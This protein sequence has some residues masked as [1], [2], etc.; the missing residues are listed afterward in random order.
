MSSSKNK[1]HLLPEHLI[2]QI[3][4][5][6]VIERPGS[7]LKEIIEN[8]IDSGA[9][10]IEITVLNNGLDLIQIRDNGCG[11]E[12]EDLPLAFARHAT[13]KISSFD[14]IYALNSFGFRGEA[15]ASISSISKIHCISSTTKDDLASEIKIEGGQVV[16][17]GRKQSL[18]RGTELTIQNLF[19][20]TPVRLKFIQSQASEKKYLKKIIFSFITSF[21][22][23][24]F[25]LKFDE[26]EKEIFSS[27][28]NVIDRVKSISPKI[29]DSYLYSNQMYDGLNFEILLIPKTF[30]PP[31]PFDYFFINS[32]MIL[33]KQFHKVI[34]QG[35]LNHLGSD[36]FFYIGILNGDKRNIDINVHPNKTS[37]KC[38][39]V[40]KIL[41]LISSSIREL[42]AK[43]ITIPEMKY[44][45]DMTNQS[46]DLLMNSFNSNDVKT[47][48]FEQH[49]NM[50]GVFSPHKS[51]LTEKS[52]NILWPDNEFFIHYELFGPYIFNAKILL[53]GF[54]EK[55]LKTSSPTTPLLVSL[56]FTKSKNLEEDVIILNKSGCEIENLNPST[57][58]LRG[59]PDWM[60]SMPIKEIFNFL[61]VHKDINNL[62]IIPSEW[63][64]EAW[65]KMINEIGLSELIKMN[66]AFNIIDLVKKNK[67]R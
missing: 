53:K 5:G 27:Q 61:L 54:L 7:L 13:S 62:N 51:L 60:S 45:T 2:D 20:N 59:I 15:L 8:S 49:Y 66:I 42:G 67:P 16:Y 46:Q 43:K 10:K 58:V 18:P 30:K 40:S 21:P 36:D 3:K 11:I 6:E 32:R 63:P 55:K 26:E 24:E 47:S 25:V 28:M 17:H 52:F 34:T 1:I 41:S 44:V 48:N 56:P 64:N 31:Y 19:Y 33:D 14:E 57:I 9:T 22:K 29:K 35:I 23:V 4:A 12:F 37:V 38:F 50:E 65:E 39:E